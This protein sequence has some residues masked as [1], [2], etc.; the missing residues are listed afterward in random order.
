MSINMCVYVCI[1][2]CMCVHACVCLYCCLCVFVLL[3]VC[4]CVCVCVG[5]IMYLCYGCACEYLHACVCARVC[6]FLY[7]CIGCACVYVC[8]L[9]GR[10]G[11]LVCLCMHASVPVCLMYVLVLVYKC[12]HACECFVCS[13]HCSVSIM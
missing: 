9:G 13:V 11:G 10:G 6:M 4:V 7:M 3:H 2:I 12:I 8:G 5:V 1:C